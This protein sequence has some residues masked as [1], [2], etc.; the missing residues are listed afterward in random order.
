MVASERSDFLRDA[1]EA[2][3]PANKAEMRG[4]L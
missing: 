2:S 1:S 4:L 3:V